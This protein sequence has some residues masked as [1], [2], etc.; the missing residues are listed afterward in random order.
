MGVGGWKWTGAQRPPFADEPGPGQESVWDFPRP[1][2]LERVPERVRVVHAGETIADTTDALRI[3]ET[4]GAPV[5][6]IPWSDVDSRWI[7]PGSGSSHCEWKGR[8]E[9]HDVAVGNDRVSQ[10]AWSYPSPDPAFAPIRDHLAFYA[11]KMDACYVGE[12]QV[13]PQPGGFYGGWVTD[14][15]AGPIKGGPGSMGW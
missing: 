15:L 10:A 1:P 7:R 4:A 5:Y 6:Y 9:Y 2:R 13:R 11:S 3:V 8:A 12:E 14:R